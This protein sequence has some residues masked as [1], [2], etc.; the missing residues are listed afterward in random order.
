M[1]ALRKRLEG[2]ADTLRQKLREV[3]GNYLKAQGELNDV[4]LEN[5]SLMAMSSQRDAIKK[6]KDELAKDLDAMAEKESGAYL[7]R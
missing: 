3:T 2:E 6:M 7:A 1:E 4:K 5:E